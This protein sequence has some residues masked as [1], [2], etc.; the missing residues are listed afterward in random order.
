MDEA[1]QAQAFPRTPHWTQ[2]NTE[3]LQPMRQS[4]ARLRLAIL[5]VRAAEATE[6][7]GSSAIRGGDRADGYADADKD[8][9]DYHA[10]VKMQRQWP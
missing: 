9:G 8:S 2:D 3:F 4:E 7:A 10:T 6:P 1:G 5:R